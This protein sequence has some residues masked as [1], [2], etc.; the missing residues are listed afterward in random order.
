MT[1]EKQLE[2]VE[3]RRLH[4]H[5]LHSP[6][7]FD[8]VGQRQFFITASCY[9]HQHYIGFRQER[10]T[11]F[12]VDLLTTC[13]KFA[14]TTYAWCV[15]PNHYHVL[16]RT[17][18][19]EA[20]R[21]QLGLL[22]GRSSYNWNGEEDR[23]GRQVWFNCVDRVIKSHR[24]FW[25]TVNYIHHNPVKHGYVDSWQDWLWSSAAPFLERVG[26]ERAL[27]IW[28]EFPILDYGKKWDFD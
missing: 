9:E 25:A 21:H 16:V 8:Y 12:E 3:Y 10:M 20:L 15:L 22:H 14:A 6:P 1:A 27:Q 13:E 17:D 18:S 4:E 28:R 5:P 26:R 11:N 2:A 19:I 23:R 7:H 24:H